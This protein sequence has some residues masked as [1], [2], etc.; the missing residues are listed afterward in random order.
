MAKLNSSKTK[1]NLEKIDFNKE[2][3]RIIENKKTLFDSKKIVIKNNVIGKKFVIADKLRL[4]EL[5]TNIFENSV[6][7]SNKNTDIT[8]DAKKEKDYVKVSI[9]DQG[10]GMTKNQIEHV[11]E[12]FYKVDSSRHDSES[13]G[14]GMTICKRIIERLNGK[15]WVESQGLGK[16]TT[17]FFTLPLY[18][19]NKK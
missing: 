10:I 16:G 18:N 1:F 2:L 12:E 6:K 13:T 9:K 8:I 3:K 5:I 17:V 7:Y 11:F 15:I 19:K 4:E 14:L